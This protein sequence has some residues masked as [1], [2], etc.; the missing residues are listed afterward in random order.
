MNKNVAIRL[1]RTCQ[2]I[3]FPSRSHDGEV[4]KYL[5]LQ[6]AFSATRNVDPFLG[7]VRT[8]HFHGTP[9]NIPYHTARS[10]WLFTIINPQ[11]NKYHR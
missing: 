1:M 11:E 10:S 9:A 2:I 6:A 7:N 5:T 4:V 8:I 3:Q